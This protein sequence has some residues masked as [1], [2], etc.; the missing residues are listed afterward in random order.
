L[1]FNFIATTFRYKEEDLMD[2]LRELFYEFGDLSTNIS[3]TNIDGLI[4]GYCLKDPIEFIF[5]I[6]QKLRDVPWEIRYLLRFI[7]IEKVVLTDILEIKDISI[8]LMKK[9]PSDESLKIQI[10][11]RHTNLKQLD[12]INEIAPFISTKVD[13][14]NPSWILLIEIIGK[15]TGISVI[16]NEILFSSMIEKRNLE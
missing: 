15:F 10:E 9:I 14:T 16:K 7:P 8:E 5:F 11:K 2:E 3:T 12:I 13:L 4:V 6:R 1:E